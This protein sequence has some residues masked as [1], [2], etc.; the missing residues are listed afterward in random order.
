MSA[1]QGRFSAAAY[2]RDRAVL[3]AA[4]LLA[5]AGAGCLLPILGVNAQ[6]TAFICLFLFLCAASGFAVDFFWRRAAFERLSDAV[7]TAR[8]VGPGGLETEFPS[9]LEARLAADACLA[10]AEADRARI[11]RLERDL[12]DHQRYVDLWVHEIKTPIAAVGLVT[13]RTHDERSTTIAREMER[14]EACVEQALYSAKA[15]SLSQDYAIRETNLGQ[16]VREA[17]MKNARLLIER[18][19]MPVFDLPEDAVVLADKP[20]LAFIVSQLVANAAKY[21]AKTVTFSSREQ[22]AGTPRGRTVLEVKDDGWGIPAADMPRVFDR[23]FTGSN[24]R[25]QG[26]A[27]GMGLYLAA[28]L[29]EAMGLGIGLA[30]EEGAG[31]RVMIA[32]PHDRRQLGRAGR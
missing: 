25:A 14:I 9:V 15:S 16:A 7:A 29:C 10:L 26:S 17:C 5:I 18:G 6:A 32:F 1:A 24:G 19:V 13:A 21:G 2:L 30:S 23:G 8:E 27:T 20:W 28:T 22:E 31:T 3:E 11:A 12:H 4:G